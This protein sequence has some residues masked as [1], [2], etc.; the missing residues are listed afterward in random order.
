MIGNYEVQLKKI[1]IMEKNLYL[2]EHFST[3][4]VEIA[5]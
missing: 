2:Q 4:V 5:R 3:L 1:Y